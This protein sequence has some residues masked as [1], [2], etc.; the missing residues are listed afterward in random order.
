MVSGS[1]QK[2]KENFCMTVL[3]L[4]CSL[5]WFRLIKNC[6]L[7]KVPDNTTIQGHTCHKR[8][9]ILHICASTIYCY[10][11]QGI[12]LCN[13]CGTHI[14]TQAHTHA[15]WWSCKSSFCLSVGKESWL[16]ILQCHIFET[17]YKYYTTIKMIFHCSIYTVN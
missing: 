12:K 8:F 7:F 9:F 4:F 16:K 5:Q 15:A 2:S 6:V 17:K 10:W 1:D 3:L 14:H 11:L 13:F